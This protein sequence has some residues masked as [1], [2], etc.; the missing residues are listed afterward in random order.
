MDASVGSKT[1]EG[2]AYRET[3]QKG[4]ARLRICGNSAEDQ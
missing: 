4:N 3:K 2:S 1:L